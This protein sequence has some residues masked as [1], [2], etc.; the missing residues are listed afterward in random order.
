MEKVKFINYPKCST[1]IKARKW[2]EE[3]KIKFD[4][5]DIVLNTPSEKELKN[6]LERSGKEIKKFF[7][8]SGMVYREMGLKNK[9]PEMTNEEC[10][11][12]LSTNGMLIKR[13]L[14][15]SKDGILIGFKEVEW[16][17][18]FKKK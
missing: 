9:L 6:Y 18:F 12:L 1:C 8:T 5:I 14:V 16:I 17:E 4:N 2:L 11:R 15:V 3:K 10:I 7:N 13:P